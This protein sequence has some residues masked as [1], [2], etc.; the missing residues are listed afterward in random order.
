MSVQGKLSNSGEWEELVATLLA[1]LQPQFEPFLTSA[2]RLVNRQTMAQLVS[3]SLPTL[4]RLVSS[5]EIP[6]MQVGTRR[7][8]DPDAVVAALKLSC[9]QN[10]R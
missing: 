3:I 4:D 5:G 6:S 2:T 1:A 7:L 8:F 9:R 10:D